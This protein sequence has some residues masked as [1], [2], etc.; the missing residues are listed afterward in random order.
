MSNEVWAII[1]VGIALGYINVIAA[2]E[3]EKRL[4]RIF[5]ILNEIRNQREKP[6]DW[7]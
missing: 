6:F 4:N 5:D 3:N 1:G 2:S 7:D